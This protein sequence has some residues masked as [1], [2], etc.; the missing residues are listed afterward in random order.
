MFFFRLSERCYL[1]D[2]IHTHTHLY[3]FINANMHAYTPALFLANTYKYVIIVRI[4]FT[5]RKEKK[6][7]FC[8]VLVWPQRM[9]RKENI[10]YRVYS[11]LLR[12]A[13]FSGVSSYRNKIFFSNFWCSWDRVV[14]W[15]EY[16]NTMEWMFGQCFTK[17]SICILGQVS[18]CIKIIN[19]YLA[20]IQ[21]S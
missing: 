20:S 14:N 11:I 15:R 9:D 12:W 21:F 17:L 5:F 13:Q 16:T 1:C 4:I 6:I 18:D 8:T 7:M 10:I 3:A 19:S 2:R